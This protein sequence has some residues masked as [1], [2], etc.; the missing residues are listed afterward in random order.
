VPYIDKIF[1]EEQEMGMSVGEG[2]GFDLPSD[3]FTITCRV[4]VFIDVAAVLWC[5]LSELA[6]TDW[7]V[8]WNITIIDHHSF[9]LAH[10]HD[11]KSLRSVTL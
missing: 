2:L 9:V 4:P 11:S 7:A 5:I 1:A 8:G 10:I 3:P 6:R